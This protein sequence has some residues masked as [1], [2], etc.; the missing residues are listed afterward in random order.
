MAAP[1]FGATMWHSHRP[2]R[3]GPVLGLLTRA[4]LAFL[5]RRSKTKAPPRRGFPMRRRGLEPPP[6]KCGPGPQ[7]V[8]RVSDPSCASR[9]SRASDA[10]AFPDARDVLDDLDVATGQTGLSGLADLPQQLVDH[11]VVLDARRAG[12]VYCAP[13]SASMDSRWRGDRAAPRLRARRTRV[14]YSAAA[15]PCAVPSRPLT[16]GETVRG[17]LSAHSAERA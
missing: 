9:A 15:R 11:G 4:Q 1:S 17:H 7:P 14:R 10:S 12:V 16:H 3:A 5:D 6:T 13:S 8:T 2:Q